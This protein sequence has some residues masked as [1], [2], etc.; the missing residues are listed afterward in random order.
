M[1]LEVCLRE[2]SWW[3]WPIVLAILIGRARVI[4]LMIVLNLWQLEIPHMFP[5]GLPVL[6]ARGRAVAALYTYGPTYR[7]PP[8]G[9]ADSIAAL[10]LER[11]DAVSAE[12]GFVRPKERM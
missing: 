10:V 1:K 6:D 8:E 3:L 12:L 5:P 11:A 2:I 4:C 9:D 7:Y